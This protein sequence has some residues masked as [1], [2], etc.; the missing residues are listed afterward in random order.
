MAA[1]RFIGRGL[2]PRGSAVVVDSL[3]HGGALA[4]LRN[5]DRNRR[6]HTALIHTA[7]ILGTEILVIATSSGSLRSLPL[8]SECLP[9]RN[10]A[11]ISCDHRMTTGAGGPLVTPSL[12]PLL[13]SALRQPTTVAPLAA[14]LALAVALFRSDPTPAYTRKFEV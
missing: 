2:C 8:I 5:F 9:S 1:R 12:S 13:P 3:W 7:L 4:R 10:L 11:V 14:H 6:D